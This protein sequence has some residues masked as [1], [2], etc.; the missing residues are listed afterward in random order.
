MCVN[1]FVDK[2]HVFKDNK[3]GS[4]VFVL[5][6]DRN[7][8]YQSVKNNI[9][10]KLSDDYYNK[11]SLENVSFYNWVEQQLSPIL[12]ST[13]RLHFKYEDSRL[14]S[15]KIHF[16]TDNPC[17]DGMSA[18]SKSN[19]NTFLDKTIMNNGIDIYDSYEDMD[20]P[21]RIAYLKKYSNSFKN[22]DMHG[23]A[24]SR[25][26]DF[27]EL[28][29]MTYKAVLLL[30]LQ[31]DK[32]ML[33]SFIEQKD[34][35]IYFRKKIKILIK[36]IQRYIDKVKI[37]E[38]DSCSSI[39]ESIKRMYHQSGLSVLF[40]LYMCK[41]VNNN[42]EDR[43]IS[44]P[45]SDSVMGKDD[46][47]NYYDNAFNQYAYP[48]KSGD[49]SKDDTD[50]SDYTPSFMSQESF[51]KSN[52][53]SLESSFT[54]DTS[55]KSD[56]VD[57][58]ISFNNCNPSF[59]HHMEEDEDDDYHISISMINLLSSDKKSRVL[60]SPISFLKNKKVHNSI[61]VCL[62]SC[63]PTLEDIKKCMGDRFDYVS[64]YDS[65]YGDDIVQ[66]LNC[67]GIDCRGQQ[68]VS[69][70]E[71]YYIDKLISKDIDMRNIVHTKMKN[72]AYSAHLNKMFFHIFEQ[73]LKNAL[74]Y[75]NKKILSDEKNQYTAYVNQYMQSLCKKFDNK[76]K[77]QRFMSNNSLFTAS[78]ETFKQ[79]Y[80]NEDEEH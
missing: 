47:G 46:M 10:T 59:D 40:S 49:E 44:S 64:S 67:L 14:N 13:D 41:H 77:L 15:D 35:S 24:F 71:I 26:F 21:L 11:L 72:T 50:G 48:W 16:F 45:S 69:D 22:I 80:L 33:E 8:N 66:I 7:K 61:I 57:T 1:A 23:L 54:S 6:Y 9:H 70:G 17:Y 25:N 18:S 65:T 63:M 79:K 36:C 53:S 5:S 39:H 19:I 34:I 38:K 73:K 76:E 51:S 30:L 52:M 55:E 3:I 20:I 42:C 60:G 58:E 27:G 78:H 43:N 31:K 62:R 29:H 32:C 4:Y 2:V 28:S 12:G 56:S 37:C 75:N 74:C 68:I